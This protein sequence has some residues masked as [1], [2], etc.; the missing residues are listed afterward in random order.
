MGNRRRN[1]RAGRNILEYLNTKTFYTILAI[2]I[3]VIIASSGVIA[4]RNYQDEQKLAQQKEQLN[5]QIADIFSETFEQI[6]YKKENHKS[7]KVIK[8]AAVGDILCGDELRE[9]AYQK[10]TN[11]YDFSSMF[12]EITTYI[13][14]SDIAIGTMETNFTNA[15][16]SGQKFCNSPKEFLT[17]VKN[18]GID[19]VSLA[20]N[21]ALDYGESGWKDTV[22]QIQ[23]EELAYTGGKREESD[24]TGNIQDIKG[25]K[26]AFLAYTYGVGNQE[27][28]TE[29]ELSLVNIYETEKVKEDLAYAK[30]NSDFIC[31]SMH[32]GDINQSRISQE[33]SEMTNFLVEN[34]ANLILGAHPAVVE[35]MEIRKN[36]QG[37]NVLIAYSLGN[38]I[39]SLN[40]DDSDVELI[41]NIELRYSAEDNDV[42]LSK[43]NYTPVYLLDNGKDAENR[44]ELVD[45]KEIAKQYANGNTQRIDQKTY[46][47]LLKKLEELEKIIRGE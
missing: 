26:I 4:F 1:K 17:A 43:V 11:T 8:I 29:E 24:F 14:K 39:S 46:E 12:Q 33:Q 13:Q 40:Y 44:Y 10:Q 28:K 42:Y 5:K 34:G 35:P 31:V 21:H 47:K 36:A 25:V 3:I 27:D 37:K 20:H 19:L 7:D 38:Y 6:A 9:D 22:L 16:Y 18:S 45:M 2:L 23:Q 32:W 30:Q 15:Q 41:L